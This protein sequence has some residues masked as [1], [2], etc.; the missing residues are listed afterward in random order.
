MKFFRLDLRTSPFSHLQNRSDDSHNPGQ[1]PVVVR[2]FE[3]CQVLF[4]HD[5]STMQAGTRSRQPVPPPHSV[6]TPSRS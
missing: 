5:L 3:P 4:S 6:A 2:R 1:G